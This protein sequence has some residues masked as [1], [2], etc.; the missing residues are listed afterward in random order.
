MEDT[1]PN[2]DALAPAS[3]GKSLYQ[4]DMI[5]TA[6]KLPITWRTK[7][8]AAVQRVESATWRDGEQQP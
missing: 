2:A 7:R 1:T 5:A 6:V 4:T 8:T 3:G